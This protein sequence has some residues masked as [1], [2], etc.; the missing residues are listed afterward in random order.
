M[1]AG[2]NNRTGIVVPTSPR[3]QKSAPPRPATQVELPFRMEM[4]RGRKQRIE[5]DFAGQTSV[6][7]YDGANGWKLRPYLNRTDYEPF[8][9]D[10]TKT[11][12]EQADLDG[13][14]VDY[15]AKGTSV[16]LAGM[17]KVD[18]HDNYKLKLTL[19]TGYSFHV[20]IDAQT[21]L[22]TK[23]EGTPRRMDG[24]YRPVEIYLLDY[25]TVNG[26]QIPRLL[27][28]RVI[29]SKTI[30]GKTQT[31]TI[32]ERMTINDV[33]VNPKLEDTLFAKPKTEVAATAPHGLTANGNPVRQ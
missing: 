7:I 10:E 29:M 16:A 21:F 31:Q 15:A 3:A 12:S 22:E 19:K 14:L 25:R 27:E 33:V 6:Q 24:E 1:E 28:T 32:A 18:G 9:A 20:W 26:L 17:E 23:I 30:G 4:K 8:T 13:P 11:A 5:L 2:G